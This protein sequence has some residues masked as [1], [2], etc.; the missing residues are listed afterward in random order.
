M[1]H[2]RIFQQAPF[3]SRIYIAWSDSFTE[4]KCLLL[5]IQTAKSHLLQLETFRRK[6]KLIWRFHLVTFLPWKLCA[7]LHRLRCYSS[8][9]TP[10]VNVHDSFT[11]AFGIIGDQAFP[12]TTS[13]KEMPVSISIPIY[14]VLQ[15]SL[16]TLALSAPCHPLQ[17]G[18]SQ[19]LWKITSKKIWCDT[20]PQYYESFREFGG[21]IKVWRGCQT[22]LNVS[23]GVT[24]ITSK[25]ITLK[26]YL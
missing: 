8:L 15:L 6:C 25:E 22:K 11:V 7:F 1:C 5:L 14:R 13:L 26:L 16:A 24:F 20:L 18:L 4:R 21:A 2:K 9:I 10:Q 23:V 3:S 19:W 17:R 12:P